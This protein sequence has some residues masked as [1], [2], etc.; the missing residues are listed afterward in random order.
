ML[1]NI[2]VICTFV[3]AAYGAGQLTVLDAPKS[4]EF[5][6]NDALNGDAVC[7]L[8]P[9]ALGYSI[10]KSVKWSGLYVADPFHLPAHTVILSTDGADKLNIGA[11]KIASYPVEASGHESFDCAGAR[12]ESHNGQYVDADLSQGI[13]SMSQYEKIFGKIEAKPEKLSGSFKPKENPAHKL[14]GEQIAVCKAL[15]ELLTEKNLPTLL[16]VRV[17]LASLA[18]DSVAFAEAQKIV[19]DVYAKLEQKI[20]EIS[21][22]KVL[23]LSYSTKDESIVKRTRR[24]AA[25]EPRQGDPI[26][27]DV[28]LAK[29]YS[30]DY[31]VIFN[32]ILWFGV[33]IAFSLLAISYAIASMDPG[34]DSI[35]YR[36]TS[37]RMK[38]DN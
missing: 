4:L 8:L 17:S 35:I 23:T 14:F 7:A 29:T 38:K 1:K 11:N 25:T 2:F 22:D 24:A 6:G 10:E 33:V 30:E 13:N 34:K 12:V 19:T 28:N 31:P 37:T 9:A 16:I 26:P 3:A 18:D 21:K 32:I 36:M 5:R 15:T 27:E 20:Q